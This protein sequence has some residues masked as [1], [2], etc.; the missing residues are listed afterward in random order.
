MSF[1]CYGRG[2]FG[3]GGVGGDF[4][5]E[6]RDL[7]KDTDGRWGHSGFGVAADFVH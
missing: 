6:W 5:G 4:G 2:G 7:P 3:P 1:T